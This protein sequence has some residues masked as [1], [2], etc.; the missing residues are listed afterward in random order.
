MDERLQKALEFSNYRKTIENEK[1]N[2]L[3]RVEHIQRFRYKTGTFTASPALIGM[4]GVMIN[5]KVPEVIV[6]D[7]NNVPVKIDDLAEFEE[8]MLS[9][10]NASMNTYYTEYNKLAKA[11]SVKKLMDW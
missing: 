2:L 7:N 1:K 11:R 3:A 8:L 9:A 4:L 6:Q 5:N 10:Y